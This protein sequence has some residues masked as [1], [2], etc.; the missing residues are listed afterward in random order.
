MRLYCFSL[1]QLKQL[2]Q[3]VQNTHSSVELFVKYT[4]R[5]QPQQMYDMLYDW[6]VN[7]KTAIFL[8]GGFAFNLVNLRDALA[9]SPY[10]WAPFHE[11]E[12][13]LYGIMT[14]I[15]I[16]LPER[17]Y[18]AAEFVRGGGTLM[19][20]TSGKV[21]FDGS[22]LTQWDIKFIELLNTFRMAV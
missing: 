8:D 3:G 4:N 1:T 15:S 18:K 12:A 17:I 7:H 21:F 22:V 13:T 6:A 16:V 11:D 9:D 2:H 14:S 10:P 19:L 20:S 5:E